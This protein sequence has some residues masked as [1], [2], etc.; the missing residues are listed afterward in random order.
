MLTALLVLL[1][2]VWGGSF[3]AI[4]VGLKYLSPFELVMARFIPSAVLLGLLGWWMERRDGA[5]S[6]FLLRFWRDLTARERLALVGL[7]FLAVPG[8]H[9]CLNTGETMI[10]AGWAGLVISLNPAAIALFASLMLRERLGSGRILGM[11]LAFA[12]LLFIALA[13]RADASAG[14]LPVGKALLGMFI[15]LGAVSSWGLFTVGS[16]R[17]MR[18]RNPLTVISVIMI[19]GALWTLPGLDGRFLARMAQGS[20]ELWGA[21]AFLVLLC[22]VVGFWLWF[23]ILSLWPASR[24]GSFIYLVPLWALLIGAAVL[25][26]R[27]TAT[28][29]LG[30]VGVVGGVFLAA[31]QPGRENAAA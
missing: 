17:F 7:S 5:S 8:Y 22:T 3:I 6:G 2:A 26:E 18:G 12:G 19:F 16:K 14:G 23:H 13:G 9:I 20:A 29:I 30:A 15:T 27:L 1:M 11:A 31:R 25:N 24:A 10:P 4:K 28:V 21:V